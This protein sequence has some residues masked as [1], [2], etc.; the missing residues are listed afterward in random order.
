MVRK[1]IELERGSLLKNKQEWVRNKIL[2]K[3]NQRIYEEKLPSLRMLAEEYNVNVITI[4]KSIKP[5]IENGLLNI[6]KGSGIYINRDRHLCI[7]I[8][9]K[10]VEGYFFDENSYGGMVSK[11]IFK[12]ILDKKDYFVF[13]Q[14]TDYVSYSGL[15]RINMS[16]D[17]LIIFVPDLDEKKELYS[18]RQPYIVVGST[19][20]DSDINYVDSD[21]RYDSERAV[22]AL[23][24]GGYRRILFVTGG[25]GKNISVELR[26]EGYKS[27]LRKSGIRYN[28][29]MVIN[30]TDTSDSLR[31]KVSS[32]FRSSSAPDAIFGANFFS[33][34][35]LLRML[36]K[37]ILKKIGLAVYDDYKRELQFMCKSYCLISQPLYKIGE[38]A[39]KDLYQLITEN[40]GKKIQKCFKSALLKTGL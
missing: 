2:E 25:R 33:T 29:N 35:F 15:L 7:G 26:L 12:N 38:T 4:Q 17:G 5:L 19:F 10:A 22:G 6:K 13:Q 40:S 8:I 21:N 31:E 1:L 39:I 20:S 32:M 18:I 16:V 28:S 23:I 34:R 24:Q 37:N 14:K 3:I 27:A 36:D 9:G 11:P 30:F